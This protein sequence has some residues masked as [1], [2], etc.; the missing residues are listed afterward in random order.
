MELSAGARALLDAMKNGAKIHDSYYGWRRKDGRGDAGPAL[1]DQVVELIA[2]KAVRIKENRDAYDSLEIADVEAEAAAAREA[3]MREKCGEL[4]ELV[5]GLLPLAKASLST[6]YTDH[7]GN[8]E[9]VVC[10]SCV[11]LDEI[12]GGQP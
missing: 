10:R 11:L 2:A 8:C 6:P 4:Y 5:I 3:R 12:E 9:C 1:D 7:D